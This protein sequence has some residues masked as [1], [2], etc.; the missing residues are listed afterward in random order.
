M[1]ADAP[2]PGPRALFLFGLAA[3]HYKSPV[4]FGDLAIGGSSLG[5]VPEGRAGQ[6]GIP[7]VLMGLGEVGRAIARAALARPELRVVAAVDPHPEIAG[8]RLADVLGLAAPDLAVVEDFDD[9]ARLARGGV[10]LLAT[11]SRFDEVL[12]D[13]QAAEIYR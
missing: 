7:V 2:S 10:L 3:V 12:P 5:T 8:R 13:L 6:S 9:V 4:I 1:C 11:H